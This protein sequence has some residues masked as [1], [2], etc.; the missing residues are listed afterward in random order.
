MSAANLI[1]ALLGRP[2]VRTHERADGPV[3]IDPEVR[4]RIIVRGGDRP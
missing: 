2:T 4:E 3:E 1:R